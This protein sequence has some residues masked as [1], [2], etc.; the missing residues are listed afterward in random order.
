MAIIPKKD[1]SGIFDGGKNSI[2]LISIIS[3][4][5]ML[6]F[7]LI[8]NLHFVMKICIMLLIALLSF[9]LFVS[10]TYCHGESGL[11]R[12]KYYIDYKITKMK[13]W[14]AKK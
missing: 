4:I 2:E 11:M 8:K 3:V 10:N 14:R 12:I 7:Q 13:E 1:K 9:Y 5:F 6:G